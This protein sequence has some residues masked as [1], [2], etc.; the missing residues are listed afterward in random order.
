MVNLSTDVLA[1]FPAKVLYELSFSGIIPFWA[2]TQRVV[3]DPSKTLISLTL[4]GLGLGDATMSLGDW[5]IL[6][7]D[8]LKE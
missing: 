4:N 1:A 5:N 3:V 8:K 7:H 2:I 6:L